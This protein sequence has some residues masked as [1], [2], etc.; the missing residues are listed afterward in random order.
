MSA[1]TDPRIDL[2]PSTAKKLLSVIVSQAGHGSLRSKEPGIATLPEVHEACGLD[3][4]GM[5]ANLAV[6]RNAGLIEVT[7]Q[8][9]FEEI[10]LNGAVKVQE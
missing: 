8:Y 4:D 3:V 10:R 6:L 2:L 9:P 1:S 5:Y 7:G